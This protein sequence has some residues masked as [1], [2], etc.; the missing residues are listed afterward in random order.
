MPRQPT[1]PT[2][3]GLQDQDQ[4]TQERGPRCAVSLTCSRM[5]PGV[6]IQGYSPV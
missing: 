2:L 3:D 5:K 1:S 4:E 6:H